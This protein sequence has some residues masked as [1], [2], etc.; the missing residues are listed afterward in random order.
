MDIRNQIVISQVM[1]PQ[2]A[3]VAGNVHGGDI[4]KQMDIAAGAVA[5]K[6]AR[7]NC[8]TARV[9]EIEFLLPIFVGA[10]VTCTASIIYVGKTSMEVLVNVDAED[11]ESDSK[12]Q[13]ALSASFTM[14]CMGKNGRPQSIPHYVPETDDEIKY[15]EK[16]KAKREQRHK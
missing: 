12:P 11:L 7:A 4:M 13:R 10:L 15:Y 2:Q 8:V 3:N 9:D 5:M 1:L 6:Y 16:I 14:V